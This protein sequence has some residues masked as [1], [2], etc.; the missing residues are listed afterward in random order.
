MALC[1]ECG[2][3]PAVFRLAMIADGKK[4]EK[5][6]CAA[7]MAQMQKRLPGIRMSDLAGVLGDLIAG[8]KK[9]ARGHE[10]PPQDESYMSL[11]C[12]SCGTTY[13]EFQKSGMVG[14]S[15]CY[16]AFYVPIEALLARVSGHKQHIGRTPAQSGTALSDKLAIDRLRQ[17][18]KQAIETEEYEEAAALRDRIRA[19]T[20]EMERCAAVPVGEGDA[21]G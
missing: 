6:L 2:M 13:E 1:E 3:R 15:D 4:Q 16:R 10:Q 7:C 14:C 5:Q 12:L 17:R 9:A 18:L 19:L 11:S 8:K 20:A 21:N